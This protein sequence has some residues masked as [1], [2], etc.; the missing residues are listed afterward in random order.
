MSDLDTIRRLRVEVLAERLRGDA[1][2]Q[3]SSQAELLISKL[4]ESIRQFLAGE[5]GRDLLKQVL[6]AELCVP[7]TSP[8]TVAQELKGHLVK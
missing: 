3:R 5:A 2:F 1:F 6:K 4:R 8:H 7:P